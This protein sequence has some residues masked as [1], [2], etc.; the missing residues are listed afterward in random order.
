MQSS[1][2]GRQGMWSLPGRRCATASVGGAVPVR[3]S[4]IISVGSIPEEKEGKYYNTSM[5]F[6][7]DGSL[8]GVFRK[9]CELVIHN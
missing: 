9:V 4:K 5:T 1:L 6:G 8:L 7:P 2:S 3:Y